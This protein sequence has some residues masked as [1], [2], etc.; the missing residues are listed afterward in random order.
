MQNILLK[1]IWLYDNVIIGNNHISINAGLMNIA[2]Y[3]CDSSSDSESI[4]RFFG[5]KSHLNIVKNEMDAIPSI[6]VEFEP[7]SVIHPANGL[8][9]KVI[10]W[11][12]KIKTDQKEFLHFL[13]KAQTEKPDLIF[14]NTITPINFSFFIKKIKKHPDL[15][16]F[17]LLHGELEYF[18]SDK[19][20]RKT[21][22][23]K[24]KYA[25]LFEKLPSN[26][27]LI[28][29]NHYIKDRLLNEKLVKESQIVSI[30]HPIAQNKSTNEKSL[31]EV[32]QLNLLQFGIANHRKNSQEINTLAH[33]VENEKCT[34]QIV[35]RSEISLHKNVEHFSKNNQA[36]PQVEYEKLIQ[37]AQYSL[38]FMKEPEYVYR[39][40]GSLLDSVIYKLPLLALKHPAV[41]E[42]F[43]LGGNIGYVFENTKD[44]ADKVLEIT[45][46]VS[47]Y[48]DEYRLQKKNLDKI[49]K[50]FSPEVIANNLKH[51]ICNN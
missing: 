19:Q 42:L 47:A 3:L 8:V 16:F 20:D 41:N 26:V 22:I 17:W 14:L 9:A 23:Y 29:L 11:I 39:V 50:L 6:Q 12:K 28:S 5:D 18:F 30:V 25:E 15:Q 27:K 43:Q 32:S 46:N 36:I 13:R 21:R 51:Y 37:N 31:E 49:K 44:M 4:V 34:V 48:Q 35:G 40:S 45:K 7:I 33:L 10:S 2:Q 1:K 24:K 38:S